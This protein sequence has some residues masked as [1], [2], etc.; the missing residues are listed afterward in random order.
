MIN[1][2]GTVSQPVLT[3]DPAQGGRAVYTF[4]VITAGDYIVSSMVNCPDEGSNSFFINIDGEPT[5]AMI[6]SIPVTVGFEDRTAT[7][8]PDTLPKQWTLSTGVHQ[9]IIRGRE[10]NAVLGRITLSVP[11]TPPD[12]LQIL[13]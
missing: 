8:S 3:V 5:T 7:W 9:L 6:W 12:G 11:P 10:A 13:P 1:G 4:N 2:D